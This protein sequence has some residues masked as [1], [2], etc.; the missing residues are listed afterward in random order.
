MLLNG[1]PI[2]ASTRSLS[3]HTAPTEAVSETLSVPSPG[4]V[5][6][7]TMQSRHSLAPAGHAADDTP[8]PVPAL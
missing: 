6:N 3:R 8:V 5:S 1:A 7:V 2:G 4:T